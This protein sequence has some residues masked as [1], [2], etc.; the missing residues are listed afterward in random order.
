MSRLTRAAIKMDSVR[1]VRLLPGG[2]G[3]LQLTEFSDNTA[4]EFDKALD[5]LLHDGATSLII[6]ERDNPGGLLDAAVA[7]ANPFSKRTNSSFI[8]RAASRMTATSTAPRVMESRSRCPW[9]CSST[10]AVPVPPKSWLALSR[11]PIARSS[12]ANGRSAGARCSR[13][14]SSRTARGC[15]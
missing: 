8:P 13:F 7:V 14:S 1:S 4:D 11:T 10:P 3:Y 9:P 15:V 12:S 5:K 6:D 2:I